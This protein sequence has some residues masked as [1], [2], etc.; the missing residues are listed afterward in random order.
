MGVSRLFH[1]TR[2][3]FQVGGLL[4]PRSTTS[5]VG[6]TAPL[7]A[8]RRT[9]VDADQYVYL[10]ADLDVAW[11]YA[12]AATGCSRP[13]VLVAMPEDPP[14]SDGEHSARMGAF[15]ASAAT[16]IEVM[17]EPTITAEQAAAG[18]AGPQCP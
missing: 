8:G 6:T 11:A 2:A 15:K 14:I 17:L 18:W 4:L 13:R 5:A 10:T 12:F 16:V 9:P 3:P 1:G 7:N